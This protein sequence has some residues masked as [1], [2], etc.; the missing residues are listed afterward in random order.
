MSE[1]SA[2]DSARL[3]PGDP[4]FAGYAD[5][6]RVA[7]PL[8]LSATGGVVLQFTDRMFLAWHSP[9]AVAGAGTAG[10]LVIC[11]IGFFSGVTGFTSVF[12]A[13]YLGSRRPERLGPAIWQ[14]LY[15]SLFFGLLTL[16]AGQCSAGVFD[17]IG[18]G[19]LVREAETAYFAATMQGGF[20]FMAAASLT[21]FFIGRGDT[22]A[23]MAVQLGGIGLNALLDY[24]MI[25]GKFGF[26]AWGVAGAAWATVLAQAFMFLAGLLLFWKAEYRRRYATWSGW[27]FEAGLTARILR[28]GTPNGLRIVVELVL[29]FLFLVLIGLIGDDELAASN[30]AFTI[31]SLAWQPMI[32]VSL[33]VSMLVGKAQGAGRPDLARLAMRRG[34][35]LAQ[36]W[37]TAAAL[38]F[39][40][41]P[42]FFLG[43]FFRDLPPE[44]AEKLMETGRVLLWYVAAYCLADSLNVVFGQGLIGA[45]DSWW[46][47]RTTLLLTIMA[48]AAMLLLHRFGAGLHGYWLV[49]ALYVAASGA[50]WLRRYF[51]GKWEAMRVVETVVVENE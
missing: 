13:Q 44:Q 23:V 4:G 51:G 3:H 50:A 27:A 6:V 12:A 49:A 43:I 40:L 16:A 37:E 29:W 45:G 7:V 19:P 14:G 46:I 42:D 47:L 30:V 34:F 35:V 25:F 31:N 5:I 32:G 48:G 1:F 38:A 10:M 9:E 11:F 33:A 20:F 8:V 21:G 28:Y 36:A 18:H 15:L 22:R 2:A 17:R 24:A 41:F 39:V 26:P